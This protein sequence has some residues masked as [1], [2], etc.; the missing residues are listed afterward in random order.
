MRTDW[1]ILAVLLK[2]WLHGSSASYYQEFDQSDINS[3]NEIFRDGNH[4]VFNKFSSKLFEVLGRKDNA[5][6]VRIKQD[7]LGSCEGGKPVDN[8]VARMFFA[9]Y[10]DPDSGEKACSFKR[11][12]DAC[13]SRVLTVGCDPKNDLAKVEIFA[14]SESFYQGSTALNP[15][16]GSRCF[17]S[18]EI[19]IAKA[20]SEQ[21]NIPCDFETATPC[22]SNKDCTG[23]T[24][25]PRPFM[26]YYDDIARFCIPFVGEPGEPCNWIDQNIY[27]IGDALNQVDECTSGS[28]CR[29]DSFKCKTR[30]RNPV[31]IPAT[32]VTHGKK[33][34]SNSECQRSTEYCHYWRCTPYIKDGECCGSSWG[35]GD[36]MQYQLRSVECQGTSKCVALY[37]AEDLNRVDYLPRPPHICRP[38]CTKDADC[39]S[40]VEVCGPPDFIY[41]LR[42]CKCN[43][44]VCQQDWLALEKFQQKYLY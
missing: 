39:V 15:K 35:M 6:R 23:G 27:N 31:V 22:M 4:K 33:C 30:N 37:S 43:S 34:S 1:K 17:P 21:L 7:F 42:Y 8:D 41:G 26:P 5:L 16:V 29:I 9:T 19:I 40:E 32:C 2:A 24:Y 13:F 36:L 44:T 28:Y 20:T 14:Q 38:A 10:T 18:D 11:N 12:A 25:C 3:N